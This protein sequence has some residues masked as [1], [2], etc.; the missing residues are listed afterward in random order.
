[1][2]APPSDSH[3][4]RQ[5]LTSATNPDATA[6]C[7][8]AA[9]QALLDYALMARIDR[10]GVYRDYVVTP[11]FE[12]LGTPAT[13]VGRHLSEGLP[14]DL[15]QQR[16]QQVQQAFAT[17]EVQQS[18]YTL[19]IAGESR[20]YLARMAP[21]NPDEVLLIVRDISSQKQAEVALRQAEQT[22]RSIFDN[23]LEGIFQTTPAGQYLSANLALAR[24]YGYDSP[25]ELI[26]QF[27][28]IAHQLYVDPDRRT[29]FARQMQTH[30]IVSHFES[31]VYRKDGSIIWIEEHARAVRDEN[32][33]ILY[34][35][36]MVE[37]ITQRKQ[38][39]AIQ[40]ANA[41]QLQAQ[42]AEL[43]R[44]LSI[45]QATLEAT[46]D[47]ILV[48]DAA[49]NVVNYNQ[50]FATMWGIPA[51]ILAS[52][53]REQELNFILEQL[54][55][56]ETF[57]SCTLDLENQPY[58]QG[59]DRF[60]L[61]DGRVFERHYRPQYLA[62]KVV[63]RVWSFREVTERIR[64]ERLK[65]EFVS[66]VSHELRTPLTSIR[67]SLGLILGGVAGALPDQA[68]MLLDIAYKNS[69]RLI[70]L[71]NDILDIEK[72]ESGRIDFNLQPLDLTPLLTQAIATNQTYGDQFQVQFV[73]TESVPCQV[74][75]D[76]DRLMQVL[77]NLLSNAAKFSPAGSVVAVAAQWL[78]T[79]PNWVR[80]AVRDQGPGIPP[81]FIPRIF[82]KFAQADSSNTRQK[83]GTGLGLSITK[84]IVERLGGKI[85]FETTQG[86]GTTFYFDLPVL[87]ET[88]VSA[89]AP[90][91]TVARRSRLLI[92]E[93]DPDIAA[94]LS[95]ILQEGGFHCD[96]A[97]SAAQAKQC[98][99]QH[100]YDA[101]T[102][103]LVL[104]DQD[105]ISFIREVRSH[106]PPTELPIVVVSAQ[107]RS[108][109]QSLENGG[110]AVMEWLEKPIDHHQL[111]S[112][113]QQ[114][115]SQS[116]ALRPRIL[117]VEDDPDIL[118]VT[119]VILRD[120]AEVVAA[121]SLAIARQQ[122]Q[123]QVFDLILLDWTLPD[124]SGLD[125]LS[126]L[127]HLATLPTTGR[128]T[129]TPLKDPTRG[130]VPPL[131][132]VIFSAQDL[133]AEAAHQVA[134]TLVK[135][136]TSNQ[137]LLQTIQRLVEHES[138]PETLSMPTS[139]FLAPPS[140]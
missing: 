41:Q 83:G 60:E 99:S 128:K 4:P 45:L 32:G 48:T 131:P 67:G 35:E 19:A 114:A 15:A 53:S 50:Q 14:P 94:L 36:G 59:Y 100:A 103:D 77:T 63:G 135:S 76:P 98:L 26:A 119:A 7:W 129:A 78:P 138:Q 127:R 55:Q 68:R 44:S 130:A 109:R 81:E 28:D 11:G 46:A 66:M 1:M 33:Q 80:V 79:A 42:Q 117:H 47:G 89:S 106:F 17:G 16:W 121:P 70:T 133:D 22:Y 88:A 37:D 126:D 13:R 65:D 75:A 137:E 139:G 18:E 51:Q 58:A 31:Q 49:W 82:Q 52:G 74:K 115:V 12:A 38:A 72:I 23:A 3:S 34:Y 125:L 29:E 97:T 87:T 118:Q 86:V 73:L 102:V 90:V 56:P 92:C 30:G 101:M 43:A 107:A 25:A 10:Q 112:V 69:E 116:P 134:A 62:G 24:I 8:E 104:P 84:A 95:L 91:S 111:L 2:P 122:L 9:Y 54:K 20:Y 136:R 113:V 124:G 105:G 57:L 5:P 71:I 93:D 140:F 27:T 40:A 6:P 110:L 96:I 108:G 85:G 123:T 21:C 64:I 120:L 61:K 132:V 39:E